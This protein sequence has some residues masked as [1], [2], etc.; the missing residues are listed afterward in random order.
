MHKLLQAHNLGRLDDKHW[1]LRHF[2][3]TLQAGETVG[4]LGLNGAGKST[5]LA[6]LTGAL[7][8][9]EGTVEVAG[10]DLHQQGAKARQQIGFLPETPALYPELTVDEN[11]EFAAHLYQAGNVAQAC[12][13]AKAR[14]D[15]DPVGS[16][17]CRKLS[18]GFQQR[19]G[20]AQALIH[21]PQI[22]VLD[23]PTAGLDPAQ[24]AEL[25]ELIAGL[26]D[27]RAIVLASHILLDIKQ[28]CRHVIILHQGRVALTRPLD[29]QATHQV[30]LQLARPPATLE[31]L[32]QI[33]GILSVQQLEENR[34][35]LDTSDNANE[36]AQAIARRDW[37][38][39]AYN[40]VTVD[41]QALL[42]QAI[43]GTAP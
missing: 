34:Y 12:R 31:A 18:K 41:L 30:E 3:L 16:K 20:I 5:A 10:Y 38:L 29:Q 22:L 33:P 42:N 19:V 37:G 23:E 13:L 36:L 7:A 14:C 24:A 6:L 27:D 11:L 32:L 43:Q 8:A 2:S 15:L 17:L 39:R 21:D 28:L 26:A 35:L 40:P 1:R 4:L 25:R 9:G